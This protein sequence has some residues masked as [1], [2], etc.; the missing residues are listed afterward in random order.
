MF[1][2]YQF[3]L[4]LF[5]NA[6]FEVLTT[7]AIKGAVFWDVTPYSDLE[8]HKFSVKYTVSIFGIYST[9]KME[10]VRSAKKSIHSYQTRRLHIP[11]ARILHYSKIS[12]LRTFNGK[13]PSVLHLYTRL[14]LSDIDLHA[15]LRPPSK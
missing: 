5:N 10:A 6:R 14:S 1:M 13:Y 4:A 7:M 3:Q 11:E 2:L 12:S 8:I 9:L 15:F